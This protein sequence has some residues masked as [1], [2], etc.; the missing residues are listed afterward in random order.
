[1]PPPTKP[2]AGETFTV[3][4]DQVE[5]STFTGSCDVPSNAGSFNFDVRGTAAGPFPGTFEERGSFSTR[6]PGFL[7]SFSSN[8]TITNTSGT[9]TVTGNKTLAGGI[10]GNRA[11]CTLLGDSNIDVLGS[12]LATAYT[13]TII[14]GTQHDSGSATVNIDGVLGVGPGT[15]SF[16]ENFGSIGVFTPAPDQQGPVQARRLADIRSVQEP[17]RLRELRRHRRK[18]PRQRLTDRRSSKRWQEAPPRRGL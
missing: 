12:N 18:E 14:N 11:S 17:G 3:Q 13:A 4:G 10:N 1:V 2:L 8:F 7:T 15:A 5:E 6:N 9:V 16:S